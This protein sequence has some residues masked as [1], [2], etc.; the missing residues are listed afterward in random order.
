MNNTAAGNN[1]G[2]NL[3]PYF[4]RCGGCTLQ[5]IDYE[6]QLAQKK[7]FLREAFKRGGIACIPDVT[8]I[9]SKPFEY[10]SRLQMRR[11]PYGTEA[12]FSTGKSRLRPLNRARKFAR[13]QEARCGFMTRSGGNKTGVTIVPVNDCRIADP[14][15]R[16][17]LQAG[18]IIPPVDRDRF[19]VYGKD[20]TL[21][22]QG[23]N[24][25]GAARIRQKDLAIDAGVFFQSNA[26]LLELL[27]DKILSVAADARKELPA[28]DFYC[29]VGTFAAFLQDGFE[30][31]DL[32]EA[33]REAVSLARQNVKH[34]GARFFG[35]KDAVWALNMGR[36]IR[37]TYGLAVVD[38]GR[39]G[40][41]AE[42][43]RFLRG[44]CEILC[45]VSC[46]PNALAR[47]TALLL[48]PPDGA[49]GGLKLEALDFYDFYPQTKHIESLA[50]FRR[51]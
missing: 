3:C 14:V 22:V 26:A 34:K 8:V 35:Q 15:I 32:L 47:D 7:E 12:E 6:K 27:I 39:Q 51:G 19:C 30:R 38:P 28:A 46:N 23:Q 29:G 40:L 13:K 43:S 5:D 2:G 21:L 17:A 45:Y 20:S 4:G 9:P 48:T 49:R 25:R 37:E 24:S 36:L 1:A 10:R 18:S 33:D 44:G 41:S 42:M 31:M 16:E 50:V 11:V